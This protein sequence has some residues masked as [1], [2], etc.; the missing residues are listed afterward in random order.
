MSWSLLV[1]LA[2]LALQGLVA[3]RAEVSRAAPTHITE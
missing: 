3:P 2:Y 1:A